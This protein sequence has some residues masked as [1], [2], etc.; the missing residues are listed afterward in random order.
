VTV[1]HWD[2]ALDEWRQIDPPLTGQAREVEDAIDRNVETVETRTIVCGTGDWVRDTLEQSMRTRAGELGIHCEIVEHPHL[3]RTQ[4][5][6]TV[7]GPRRKLDEF[8]DA[9]R[10]RVSAG[11]TCREAMGWHRVDRGSADGDRVPWARRPG[12][13]GA[14]DARP[15]AGRASA[16]GS[17]WR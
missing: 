7:T 12:A 10:A 2:E 8:R 17:A 16:R 6:F 1:S 15:L 13:G 4:V 11:R 14:C 3:L 5:A 9:R